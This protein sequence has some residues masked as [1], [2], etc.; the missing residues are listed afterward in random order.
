MHR[1][2]LTGDGR[3]KFAGPLFNQTLWRF[4][5]GGEEVQMH[6]SPVINREGDIII[7]SDLGI[8]AVHSNGTEKWF[9]KTDRKVVATPAITNDNVIIATAWDGFVRA[10]YGENGALKWSYHA[11][12]FIS[13]SPIIGNDGTIFVCDSGS[14]IHALHPTN[15]TL[16]WGYKVGENSRIVSTPALYEYEDKDGQQLSTWKV[17][18]SV[19]VADVQEVGKKNEKGIDPWL[20]PSV[21]AIRGQNGRWR[22]AT[23]R[24]FG[25]GLLFIGVDGTLLA[26]DSKSGKRI[27]SH[28]C[29]GALHASPTVLG[30]GSVLVVNTSGL[31]YRFSVRGILLW[32]HQLDGSIPSSS[33]TLSQDGTLAYIGGWARSLSAV[34]VETGKRA[35]TFPI[36]QYDSVIDAS[37]IIDANGIIYVASW[38]GTLR[39]FEGGERELATLRWTFELGINKRKGSSSTI[40]IGRNNT[41]YLGVNDGHLIAV[42]GNKEMREKLGLNSM[43]YQLCQLGKKKC[44]RKTISA[45]TENST[46]GSNEI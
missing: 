5:V 33:P 17:G 32:K 37:P 19:S 30:D 25:H 23:D 4:S 44:V 13:S 46:K 10:I 45:S 43:E 22:A 2:G 31:M 34:V 16:I 40:A 21:Y 7:G 41:A 12:S 11:S 18:T 27:W 26:L 36:N 15:G 14:G 3:S 35:W 20:H 6:S 28:D 8:H 1:G 42:G 29:K 38:D 9:F 24:R 39:A